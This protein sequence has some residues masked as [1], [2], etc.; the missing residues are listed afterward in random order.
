MAKKKNNGTEEPLEKQLWKAADK[1]RKNIDAVE[2]KYI[3]LGL[4]FLKYIS[5]AFE[6]RVFDPCC[7]SGG[8]FP[9]LCASAAVTKVAELDYVLTP[10]RYVGLPDDEDDFDFK[11]RFTAF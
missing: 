10:G 5:D 7:G 9:G 4:I 11:E 8:M 6:E 3:V 2:Y 1:L